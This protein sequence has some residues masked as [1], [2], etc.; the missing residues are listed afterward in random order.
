MLIDPKAYEH[1]T[2]PIISGAIEVHR[3]LGAGLLESVYSRCLQFELGARKLRFHVQRAVPIVYKG[4]SLDTSYRLDLIVEDLVVVEV[5]S[6]AEI[7]PVHRSQILTYLRLADCPLGLII[8]F[9]VPLLADGVKRGTQSRCKYKK[10]GVTRCRGAERESVRRRVTNSHS[11]SLCLRVGT[12]PPYPPCP[13]LRVLRPSSVSRA[14][15]SSVPVPPYP[16]CPR[17]LWHHVCSPTEHDESPPLELST[18]RRI[19][20]HLRAL[21]DRPR[22]RL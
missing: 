21:S 4:I 9:H 7:L 10:S 12:V 11:V 5:K 3:Q 15:V 19:P 2:G 22:L 20:C 13:C 16:P 14:S 6:A 8:N 1:I 18:P 17:L